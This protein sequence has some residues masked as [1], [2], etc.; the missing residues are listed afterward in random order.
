MII[1]YVNLFISFRVLTEIIIRWL[2]FSYNDVCRTLRDEQ[3]IDV[4]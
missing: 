3:N 4:A 2:Y 1:S